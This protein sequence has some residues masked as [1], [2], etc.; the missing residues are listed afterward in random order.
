MLHASE[1][2]PLFSQSRHI[3][4][5]IGYPCL[6]FY[7]KILVYLY[8]LQGCNIIVVWFMQHVPRINGDV[9]SFDEATSDHQRLLERYISFVLYVFSEI[10]DN[11]STMSILP[12][13]RKQ[14]SIEQLVYTLR[15]AFAMHFVLGLK[16]RITSA[17]ILTFIR[18]EVKYCASTCLHTL[19]LIKIPV[20]KQ[21]TNKY[22]NPDI[23]YHYLDRPSL[24]Y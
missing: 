10:C 9:P 8:L 24:P 2:Q 21:F 23:M 7:I 11:F 14:H 15:L 5:T 18:Q 20:S 6:T 12:E 17:G 16:L 1:T 13:S 19:F 3:I 22:L 4:D